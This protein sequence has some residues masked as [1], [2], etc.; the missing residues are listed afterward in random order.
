MSGYLQRLVSSARTPVRSIHP[1]IGSRFSAPPD[2]VSPEVPPMMD[3]LPVSPAE[4]DRK[5]APEA[6]PVRSHGRPA[7]FEA[8]RQDAAK[9]PLERTFEPLVPLPREAGEPVAAD[10]F[11]RPS[12]APGEPA[13]GDR[14][15]ALDHPHQ[16]LVDEATP[17]SRMAF[18]NSPAEASRTPRG[19][20]TN[21]PV[22]LPQPRPEPDEI[23]IHIGR[24]EVTAV[25]PPPARPAAPPARKSLNLEEYLKRGE[26]RR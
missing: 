17:R 4:L 24:I 10:F 8:P 14:E 19:P 9:R 21:L 15:V 5:P 11:H 1:M 3:Q 12:A 23:E 16:P 20:R 7:A 2:G 25:L 26:R 6:P 13:A 18:R 22:R